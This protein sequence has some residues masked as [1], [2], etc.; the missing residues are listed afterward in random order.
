MSIPEQEVKIQEA[1]WAE[2]KNFGTKNNFRGAKLLNNPLKNGEI[3]RLRNFLTQIF[4]NSEI[5]RAELHEIWLGPLLYF[6]VIR[7]KAL[8]HLLK[9]RVDFTF[10]H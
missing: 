7:I 6:V 9:N 8:I 10:G 2:L 4:Q 5:R 3:V 1:I